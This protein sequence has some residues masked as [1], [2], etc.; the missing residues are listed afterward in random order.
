[1][2][3]TSNAGLLAPKTLPTI[4]AREC[5]VRESPME[6]LSLKF[7]NGAERQFYRVIPNSNHAV[8]II[9][10]PDANSV[11]IT[12]EYGCGFHRYELGLPRGRIDEGED[13]LVAANRE[14]QEET[15]F[16]AKRLNYLRTLSLAPTYMAHEI[17]VVLARDLYP[18]QLEGDEPEPIDVLTWKLAEIEAL[19]LHPE[20]T[21]GRAMGAL[22]LARAWLAAERLAAERTMEQFVP[23]PLEARA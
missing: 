9:A 3:T 14:L 12:R 11:L 20:F 8:I 4:E 16:G 13:V 10:M 19:A 21:E 17:H 6:K 15:G 18:N 22:L 5:F 23:A 7:S 2:T 1:M